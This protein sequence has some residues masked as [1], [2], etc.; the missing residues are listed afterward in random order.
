[1]ADMLRL[2][3]VVSR[4]RK[5]QSRMSV[6]ASRGLVALAVGMAVCSLFPAAGQDSAAPAEAA[7]GSP[8]ASEQAAD[9]AIDVPKTA[10]AA[11]SRSSVTS[12]EEKIVATVSPLGRLRQGGATMFFLVALSVGALTFALERLVRLRRGAI[13]PAGLAE[14]A[15]TL[16]LAGKFDELLALC[17]Q[18]PSTLATIIDAF[19]RHRHC[20]ALELSA[21][22]GDIA[23]RDMRTHLQKAYPLAVVATLSPLL[24]LLGTVIGMIESF[25]VVAI[26]GSLGDASLLAGGISKALVTTATGLVI[27]VPA[28]GLYHFFKSRTA[29]H[30]MAL[31]G[32]VNE[33]L[34]SWF[35]GPAG[36]EEG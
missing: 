20:S 34:T 12:I 19:V 8:A 29:T 2:D 22:A 6:T 18:R 15:M 33:L 26:A 5:G 9:P 4:A 3:V 16:W 10:A 32:E 28:L 36:A 35:M 13:N 23:G 14:Q 30:T 25:E 7:T 24:G 21:L 17:E 11:A 1:M 31:E 27:A